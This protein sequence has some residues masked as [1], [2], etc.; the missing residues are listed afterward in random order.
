MKPRRFAGWVGVLCVLAISLTAMLGL[1]QPSLAQG[2]G[3][4]LTTLRVGLWPEYDRP[5]LLVIYWGEVNSPVGF[6]VTLSLRIPEGVEPFVVAAQPGLDAPVDEV[7]FET[8]LEEGWQVIR[9][10]VHG[11]LF[12]FE[13][14]APIAREGTRRTPA[15]TWPGDYSVDA[16]SIELQQPPHSSDLQTTPA[17]PLSEVREEDNLVYLG[18]QFGPLTA[19]QEFALEIGYTRDSDELTADLLSALAASSAQSTGETIS[20]TLAAQ[21]SSGRTDIVLIVAVAVV[22]F[23]LGAATMR[24]AINLQALNRRRKP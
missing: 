4:S 24:I 22:F 21:Q 23:L 2:G 14:Y 20:T 15:F 12:Q 18:G 6:P 7:P 9:F 19:G 11:P 13:Y 16:L 3:I 5:E 10:E 8:A 1:T 17:L